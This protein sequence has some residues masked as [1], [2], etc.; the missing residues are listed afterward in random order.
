[1]K[2]IVFATNN[3]H[4][5]QEIREIIGNRFQILSLKDIGCHEDIPE[6]GNTFKENALIKAQFVKNRFGF[7]CFADD[8]GLEVDVLNGDPGVFSSRYGGENG[9]AEKN[10]EKLLKNLH[11]KSD[12]NA[13]F[14][15]VIALIFNDKIHYF[16]GYIDGTIIDEKKGT[17]GFG[18]DPIFVPEGY[19]KTFAEL[20]ESVKNTISHRANATKKLIEFLTEQQ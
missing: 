10:M 12:R 19:E 15:T 17:N 13:R 5:L 7:D 20:D 18:Y 2:E 3:L 8:S 1:M 6:T 11:G 16:E 4:K 9:N 14:R